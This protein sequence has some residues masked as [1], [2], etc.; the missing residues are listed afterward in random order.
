MMTRIGNLRE[1]TN[2]WK[3]NFSPMALKVLQEN[4]DRSMNCNIEFNEVAGFEVREG[5]CQHTVDL[6]RRTCSCRVWQLKGI[7]CAHI[8]IY[9][10]KCDLVDYID[11]CYSKETYLR[12]YANVL[13]P[14]TNMEICP[15]STNPTVAPP[16]T[17]SIPGR[18]SKLRRKEAGETKKPRK[19]PRTGL[20]MTCSNCNGRGH[21]KRGC[22]QNVQSSARE[23]PSGSGNGRGST[24]SSGRER[25]KT[26]CSG[27]GRGRPKNPSIEGEPPVKRGRGRPRKTP[28]APSTPL[29]YPT[30]SAPP[31]PTA[32]FLP[33]TSKRGRPIKTPHAHPAYL[34]HPTPT[35]TKRRPRKTPHVHLAYLEHPT[36][37]TSLPTTSKRERGRGNVIQK[38]INHGMSVFQAE[39]G[40]KAFNPGMPSLKI[41]YWCNQ[42]D[43][44]S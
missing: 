7:P 20:A 1:F 28:T 35:T 37:P 12:T 21:N 11:S 26:S 29:T 44:I 41:L 3:C 6:G 13:Q 32:T 18:P 38:I 39:N 9:F 15:I 36:P 22:L 4:I 19:L 43:K 8:V 24:S 40:F 16:E 42:S 33:T 17:K 27:R 25:G 5:L 10:K 34:E 14:I 2:T 23:E 31:P 30:H